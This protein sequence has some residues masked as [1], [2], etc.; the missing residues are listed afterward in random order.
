MDANSLLKRIFLIGL[1]SALPTFVNAGSPGGSGH[2]GGGSSG[3]HS[4]SGSS[5][6]HAASGGGRSVS[7]SRASASNVRRASVSTGQNNRWHG[8]EEGDEEHHHRH[9]FFGLS[10]YWYP[11]W[12]GYYDYGYPYYADYPYNYPDYPNGYNRNVSVE[13]FVQD[14]L[15][16]RGYYE[17]RVDGVIGSETRSAIREFQH[18]NGLPVTGR[19]NSQLMQALQ[20]GRD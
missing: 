1:I 8:H 3:G 16:R 17:G 13:V 15:A 18:D 14:A 4:A 12:G 7:G 19:I 9:F 10:P 11:G 20:T 5:G 6:G 2:S